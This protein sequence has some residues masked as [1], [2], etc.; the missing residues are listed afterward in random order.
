MNKNIRLSERI[1]TGLGWRWRKYISTPFAKWGS[2]NL[3]AP[4]E[5]K[6]DLSKA[7]EYWGHVPRAKGSEPIFTKKFCE[8]SNSEIAAEFDKEMK[9]AL[10]KPERIAAFDMASETIKNMEKPQVIDYG[11]GFGFNGMALLI[12]NPQAHVTFIDINSDNLKTVEKNARAKGFASRTDFFHVK[13]PESKDLHFTKMF[14]MIVSM[15]VLHHTPHAPQIVNR[16][17]E[18]LK[19]NGFFLVMLYNKFYEERMAL[20]KKR[21]LNTNTFGEMTDPTVGK[22]QNPYSES[23]DDEKTKRL[24]H[25]YQL[26]E[27]VYPD[28]FYN[29]YKFQKIG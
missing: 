29:T 19:P 5:M 20:R 27:S 23:Y 4:A 6:Y 2:K 10:E 24:F 3:P 11:S 8:L 1:K 7:Q 13:H 26:L 14:D 9:T 12:R 22:S 25:H 15:G 16:L 28:P 18:F 21:K 17:S